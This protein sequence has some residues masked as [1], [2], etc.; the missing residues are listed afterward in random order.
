MSFYFYKSPKYVRAIA[1]KADYQYIPE[2]LKE[3]PKVS[4]SM[5]I[6]LHENGVYSTLYKFN[7]GYILNIGKFD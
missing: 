3:F 4:K 5:K 6:K 1:Y 7:D 2:Y